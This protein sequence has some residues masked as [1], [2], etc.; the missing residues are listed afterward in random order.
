ML[1]CES[2]LEAAGGLIGKPSSGLPGDVRRMIIE[3]Q[4]DRGVGRVGPVEKLEKLDEFPAAAMA[5]ST[6][7]R[8]MM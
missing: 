7:H 2:E 4:M 3:D 5:R 6:L 8:L 1:G